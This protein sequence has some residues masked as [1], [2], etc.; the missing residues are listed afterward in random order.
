MS[1]RS[2]KEYLAAVRPRY[3]TSSRAEKSAILD[4]VCANCGYNRKYAIFLLNSK[5]KKPGDVGQ[6]GRKKVYD[7]PLILDALMVVWR[8]ANLPCAKRL[9]AIIPLWLPYFDAFILPDQVIEK[10]LTISASTIDRLMA[11][12]R[13]KFGKKGLATTKPGAIL[14]KQIPIKTNQWDQTIPGFI[15]VDTV[16]HCDDSTAGM[17]AYTVN[18]VDIATGWT[19]QRAVWG[20][21][22]NGVLKAVQSIED[23]LP[24]TLKG[25][26][27][28]NGS[29]FINWH[30]HRYL[31]G[32]RKKNPVQF[33][34]ARAY[35]KNDNAH[36]EN[37][38]WTHVRQF[39]GYQ[40]FDH[41][42]LA[43]LLNQIYTTEWRLYHNFFMASVKLIAKE[44]V[45]SRIIKVHDEP[46]T[47]VQRL[48][49]SEHI[50]Q[51]TKQALRDQ[52]QTLNPFRL[53]DQLSR[54]IRTLLKHT[55]ELRV[56]QAK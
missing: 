12:T 24:F 4:E 31:T 45:G 17:F 42:E 6:R 43:D 9:K 48:L 3:R 22:E 30:L 20:K 34:R 38:N 27:C 54:R 15:E 19:E 29:E 56:A 53:H 5:E 52:L 13:S 1:I 47:P 10:L 26:D 25:F 40:R 33:T 46:K 23:A 51:E 35:H 28:D 39:I 21:G 41:P 8:A 18:A 11:P 55:E 16:A 36:V 37:K 2:R 32:E 50:S 44:R 7:D 14:K 49:E